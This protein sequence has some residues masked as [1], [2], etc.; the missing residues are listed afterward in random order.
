MIKDEIDG[1]VQENDRQLRRQGSSLDQYLQE[2]GQSLGDYRDGLREPAINRIRFFLGAKTIADREGFEA[3]REDFGRYAYYLMQREGLGPEQIQDL[4]KHREFF[5]EANYQ[6]VL[7]KVLNHLVDK[8]KFT[9]GGE[10]EEAET[11]SA[12]TDS[13]SKETEEAE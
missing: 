3:S 7:E 4:M 6:I 11:P 13:G 1:M 12:E 9:V 5:N 2:K 10:T 8:V